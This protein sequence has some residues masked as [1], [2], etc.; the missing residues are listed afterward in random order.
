MASSSESEP[1][2]LLMKY[3]AGSRMDSPTAMNAAKWITA[4][5]LRLRISA[6]QRIGIRQVDL[7]QPLGGHIVPVP[8]GKVVDHRNVVT[9][10]QQLPHR[11]RADVP[12]AARD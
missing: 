1:P 8:L 3:R 7:E 12:G 5:H 11:V 2:T 9:F 6:H 10:A 4:S